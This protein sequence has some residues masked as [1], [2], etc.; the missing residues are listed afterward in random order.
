MLMPTFFTLL[1]HPLYLIQ[2]SYEMG[3]AHDDLSLAVLS[4]VLFCVFAFRAYQLKVLLL[5]CSLY[6][7]NIYLQSAK[8]H[9]ICV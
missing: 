5:S 4:L 8:G 1:L 3:F 9:S 2:V 7:L 6:V